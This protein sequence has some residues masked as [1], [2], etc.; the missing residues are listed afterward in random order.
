MEERKHIAIENPENVCFNCLR[1]TDVHKFHIEA[2]GYGS[3]FDNF[4]TRMNLCDD[5]LKLTNPEWWELE[6]VDIDNDFGGSYKYEDEILKFAKQMPVEGQELFYARYAYGA[7][8]HSSGGQD[9]IDYKLGILPHEKCKEYG[10]Y[11]PQEIQAYKDRF[12]NCKHVVIKVYGDGSKGSWCPR[13]AHGDGDG[14]CG[15]NI[16]DECY[17]CDKFIE[18]DGEI[19]VVDVQEEFYKRETQRLKEMIAYAEERLA[20]IKNKTLSEY[21]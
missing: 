4:S 12:P 21:D 20:K 5:C 11:S 10:W 8:A 3:S 2:L 17:L 14:N 13:G 6:I 1:E 16:S 18:R 15:L 19:K 7:C 9:W